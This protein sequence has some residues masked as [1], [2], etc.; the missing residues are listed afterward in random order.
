MDRLIAE[1]RVG[2]GSM[3]RGKLKVKWLKETCFWALSVTL[4]CSCSSNTPVPLAGNE[5]PY[6]P[7]CVAAESGGF[8][9]R[10]YIRLNWFGF[11]GSKGSEIINADCIAVEP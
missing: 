7:V 8:Q 10:K 11:E 2:C 6:F 4:L 9:E 5:M 3:R 1:L